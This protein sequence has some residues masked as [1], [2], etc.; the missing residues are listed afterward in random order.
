MK[1]FRN[2]LSVT[3]LVFAVQVCMAQSKIKNVIIITTDGF[4]WQ[5]LF[6]GA[7]HALATNKTYSHGDSASILKKYWD[8]NSEVARAKM[9]PFMWGTMAGQGQIYGN[10]ALGNLMNTVNPYWFSY[11]GYN[12]IFTGYPDTA[13]NSNDYKSNPNQT[14]LDYLNKQPQFKGRVAAFT[15]WDAFDRILNKPGSGFPV[16]AAFEK[17]GGLHPTA[18]E[19]LLN[20]MLADSYRPFGDEECLDVFTH[21]A[22][23]EYLKVKKPR[24]LYISYGETDEWAHAGNYYAYLN[25]VHQVDEWLSDIWNQIQND[26]FYKDQTALIITTDHGRGNGN[27]WTSH[28]QKIK[29]ASEIWFAVMG[30]GIAAKGEVKQPM[31]NHQEQLAQTIASLLGVK[32]KAGHPVADKI[33]LQ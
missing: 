16:T 22:A 13:V 9:M 5:E 25:A 32:F 24:V 29:G 28:G 12:E 20:K 11:P 19:S 17:S 14:V 6:N 18:N 26:P 3:L 27:E 10:R 21:Y 7:D 15:A 2:F 1:S 30:P 4:R 8:K 23:M 33:S 31:Q